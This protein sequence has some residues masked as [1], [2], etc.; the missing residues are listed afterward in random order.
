MTV[1]TRARV[2]RLAL[3]GGV[4]VLATVLQ[5][6]RQRGHAPWDT[7]QSDDGTGFVVPAWRD[8]P[9]SLLWTQYAGY[10]QVL[11]RLVAT[12]LA[13]LPHS[14]AAAYGAVTSSVVTA[15]LGLFVVRASGGLVRQPILRWLLGLILVLGPAVALETTATIAQLQFPLV[16]AAFWAIIAR[17]TSRSFL[18]VRAGVVLLAALSSVI[19]LTLLPLAAVTIAVRRL[20]S[21]WVVGSALGVGAVAQGITLLVVTTPAPLAERTLDGIIG[22]YGQRVAGATVVGGRWLGRAWLE[23]GTTLSIVSCV[24][25]VAF[26]VVLAAT[27]DR[28]Q[29]GYAGAAVL[30]SAGILVA[31]LWARGLVPLLVAR[32]GIFTDDGARYVLIPGWLLVSGLVLLAGGPTRTAPSWVGQCA[33]VARVVLVIQ[34]I[35]VVAVAFR[36]TNIR[37]PGPSF[38]SELRR[39]EHDCRANPSGVAYPLF[40]PPNFYGEIPC[41]DL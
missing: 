34:T 10:L 33:Q 14:W 38:A 11:P 19:A 3:V 9:I 4:L 17:P 1:E 23:L 15:L 27:T 20:R 21:D 7:I 12:P 22:I 29:W 13:V 16:F 5:L 26:A 2:R 24:V 35:L 32:D 30:W 41:E 40:S 31:S 36:V 28:A 18:A 6:L 8:H 37:S 39:T 25:L